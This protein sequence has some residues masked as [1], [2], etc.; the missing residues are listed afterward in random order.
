MHCPHCNGENPDE[1][2]FCAHCGKRI[3]YCQSC[4]SVLP[5][6]ATFCVVCGAD[7]TEALQGLRVAETSGNGKIERALRE[8]SDADHD[9]VG[10]FFHPN[11][12]E[13][14]LA[15]RQGDNTIGAGDKNDIVIKRPAVSWNHALLIARYDRV[16]IQDSASTNGTFVEDRRI[17]RPQALHH[18][19]LVRFGNVELFVWLRPGLRS[20]AA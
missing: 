14:H 5:S 12:P 7:N 6:G 19:A 11:R 13:Q 2:V 1:A 10:F 15:I 8:A 4:G 20:N 3:R 9:I 17:T 16:L 18:G